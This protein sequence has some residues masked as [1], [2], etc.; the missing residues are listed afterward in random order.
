MSVLPSTTCCVCSRTTVSLGNIFREGD[1]GVTIDGNLV[2]IV[3]DD[4]LAKAD[5]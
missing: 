3:E 5:R 2:V 4:Q 1:V